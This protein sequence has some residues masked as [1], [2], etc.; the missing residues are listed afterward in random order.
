MEI[1]VKFRYGQDELEDLIQD[2]MKE[3]EENG[4]IYDDNQKLSNQQIDD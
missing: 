1:K 4:E 3:R 2:L